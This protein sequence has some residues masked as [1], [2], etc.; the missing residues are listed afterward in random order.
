[1]ARQHRDAPDHRERAARPVRQLPWITDV[2]P[3]RS[4]DEVL[5]VLNRGWRTEPARGGL[6]A[7]RAGLAVI[8]TQPEAIGS[9]RTGTGRR[10]SGGNG[11]RRT[12]IGGKRTGGSGEQ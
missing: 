10:R 7:S 3:V 9:R 12:G 8:E 5:C 1:P 4:V 6:D 11:G 2:R